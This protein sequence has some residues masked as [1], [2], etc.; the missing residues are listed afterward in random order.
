MMSHEE[1]HAYWG[2]IALIERIAVLKIL[3][4]FT[5][6]INEERLEDVLVKVKRGVGAAE[7]D[8]A[9]GRVSVIDDL[10]TLNEESEAMA[11]L[12]S[13]RVKGRQV[14][15]EL[16][17]HDDYDSEFAVSSLMDLTPYAIKDREIEL[18]EKNL[19]EQQLLC[20]ALL[21]AYA[22]SDKESVLKC[23]DV[24]EERL[25]SQIKAM[26]LNLGELRLIGIAL[27]LVFDYEVA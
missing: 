11:F 15:R 21:E 3:N 9:Y 27:E 25:L 23:L 20:T 24:E 19:Q 1:S 2:R 10:I 8:E 6:S 7:L 12:Q 4:R 14:A 13:V 26:D 18:M 5:G 17:K 16:T 22:A